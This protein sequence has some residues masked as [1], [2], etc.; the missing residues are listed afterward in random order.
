MKAFISR[1]EESIQ[2]I[3]GDYTIG[4]A[5]D[6][7]NQNHISIYHF[8]G[9]GGDFNKEAFFSVVAKSKTEEELKEAVDL[10]FKDNF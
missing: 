10:F 8:S 2:S 6:G 5:L 7:D 4:E 9:E 3:V 1:H